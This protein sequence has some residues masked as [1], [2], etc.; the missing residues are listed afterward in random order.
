MTTD[1]IKRAEKEQ[2]LKEIRI[3]ISREGA[4]ILAACDAAVKKNSADEKNIRA[5]FQVELD[6][7]NEWSRYLKSELNREF[8]GLSGL[9]TDD[10]K[11]EDL[12]MPRGDCLSYTRKSIVDSVL[13]SLGEDDPIFE[14]IAEFCGSVMMIP[15]CPDHDLV[16]R[17]AKLKNEV[18]RRLK[19]EPDRSGGMTRIKKGGAPS[20]NSGGK[21]EGEEN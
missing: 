5:E 7:L 1:Q 17:R 13:E 16:Q 14:I 18:K 4:L 19:P 8:P 9:T 6:R 2:R 21:N 15:F 11:I 3:Q 20:R 12:K 10:E